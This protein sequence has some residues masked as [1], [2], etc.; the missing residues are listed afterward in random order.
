ML[1]VNPRAFLFDRLGD[2]LGPALEP[3]LDDLLEA[4]TGILLY[5]PEEAREEIPRQLS[6]VLG[7]WVYELSDEYVARLTSALAEL[8]PESVAGITRDITRLDL[9][10]ARREWAAREHERAERSLTGAWGRNDLMRGHPI[11]EDRRP[12]YLRKAGAALNDLEETGTALETELASVM[13]EPPGG[14]DGRTH[15]HLKSS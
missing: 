11:P 10:L 3:L 7:D 15:P 8:L 6:I 14:N 9:L 13:A 2:H 12:D 5:D 4:A 1:V